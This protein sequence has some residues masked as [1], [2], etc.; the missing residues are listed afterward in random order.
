MV[1]KIDIILLVV[2]LI[3]GGSES[4]IIKIGCVIF[5]KVFIDYSL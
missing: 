3:Y 4:C 2:W 5:W 1:I